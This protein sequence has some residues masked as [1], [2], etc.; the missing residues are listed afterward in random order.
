VRYTIGM[1][2]PEPLAQVTPR[3]PAA[4]RAAHREGT[5]VLEAVIGED[6]RVSGVQVLR[7][8]GLGCDEAAVDAV[9]QWRFR[10]ASIQGRPIKILYTLTVH[11]EL[12]R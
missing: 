12:R 3:Y 5:V 11:F 8:L 4:A 6:G 1:T 10:P 7:G 2:R 9:R